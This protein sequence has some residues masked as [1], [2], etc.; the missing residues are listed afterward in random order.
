[1]LFEGVYLTP[2][3]Q[4]GSFKGETFYHQRGVQ[5]MQMVMEYTPEPY[6]YYQLFC[7]RHIRDSEVVE[8]A[9]V[10]VGGHGRGPYGRGPIQGYFG[11]FLLTKTTE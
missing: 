1:M 3:T 4:V 10:D 6:C 2:E 5:V 8:G 11:R 7:G 9:W